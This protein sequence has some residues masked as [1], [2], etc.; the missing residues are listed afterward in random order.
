M[1]RPRKATCALPLSASA[2]HS[3]AWVRRLEAGPQLERLPAAE[4]TTE[5]A[6]V[7]RRAESMPPGRQSITA[8]LATLEVDEEAAAQQVS[9]LEQAVEAVE[10]AAARAEATAAGETAAVEASAQRAAAAVEVELAALQARVHA[11]DAEAEASERR[12]AQL[13]EAPARQ[14]ERRAA[15]C[16]RVEWLATRG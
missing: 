15:A 8:R 10:V 12:V 14:T 2:L 9:R 5:S 1:R 7:A 16:A 3:L 11:A 13:T 4:Y 6:P